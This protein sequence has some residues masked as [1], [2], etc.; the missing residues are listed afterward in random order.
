M[1]TAPLLRLEPALNFCALMCAVVVHDQVHV[2]MGGKLSFQLVEKANQFTAAMAV[3]TGADHLA[4]NNVEGGKQR[5]CTV[6]LIV[7]GLPLGQARS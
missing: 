2:L 1:E 5:R 6:T 4:V 7:V 3:L